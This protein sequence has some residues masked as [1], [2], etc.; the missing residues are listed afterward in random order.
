MQEH[1]ASA[2]SDL[3]KVSD[4]GGRVETKEAVDKFKDAETAIS[5][6]MDFLNEQMELAKEA[7]DES[8]QLQN[9]LEGRIASKG[10]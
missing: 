8:E 2:E 7:K 1:S 10:R 6:D 9:E 5:E 4:A 3:G